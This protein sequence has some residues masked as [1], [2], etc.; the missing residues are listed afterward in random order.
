MLFFSADYF[1]E[2]FKEIKPRLELLLN[3]SEQNVKFQPGFIINY[4]AHKVNIKA[5]LRSEPFSFEL[6]LTAGN[7]SLGAGAGWV[8]SSKTEKHMKYEIATWWEKQNLAVVAKHFGQFS[9][10]T[11]EISYTIK[12][13]K[14][15]N[16]GSIITMNWPTRTP[17]I[18]IG[19]SYIYNNAFFKG[20]IS[21][22]GILGLSLTRTIDHSISLTIGTEFDT[23]N[24]KSTKA[25]N[26]IF[27][28]FLNF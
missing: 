5:G 26:L 22:N 21:S 8:L 2:K 14:N 6:A 7:P 24:I 9:S 16:M 23:K 1:P 20:K 19:A 13:H 10:G 27:G 17:E 15:I 4:N 3:Y 11:T 25:N 28:F 18:Q 12:A